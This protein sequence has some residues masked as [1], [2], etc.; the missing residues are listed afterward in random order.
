VETIPKYLTCELP[1]DK[2]SEVC[3]NC[4]SHDFCLSVIE[5]EEEKDGNKKSG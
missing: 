4:Q 2:N 1:F 3:R 5:Q